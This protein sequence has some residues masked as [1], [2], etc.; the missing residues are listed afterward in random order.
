MI[1][2]RYINKLMKLIFIDQTIDELQVGELAMK[3]TKITKSV[4][5]MIDHIETDEDIV[6]YLEAALKENDPMLLS[7]VLIDIKR[8][9]RKMQNMN[10]D[11]IKMSNDEFGT[12]QKEEYEI[13]LSR[14]FA[15]LLNVEEEFL[16]LIY[17]ER[18]R[19]MENDDTLSQ[20]QVMEKHGISES[21]LEGL[22]DV[23]IE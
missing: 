20:E 5:D 10:S 1:E 3:K 7:A 6:R 17:N 21:D 14:I 16:N 9:K 13:S 19:K 22:E 8:T 4:W 23:E 15:L 11:E 18:L 12:N 2:S